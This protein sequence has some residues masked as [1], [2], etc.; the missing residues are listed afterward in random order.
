VT[1]DEVAPEIHRIE[2]DIGPRFVAQ[3]LLVGDE[4]SV[5]VDTGLAHTPDEALAPA[6]E[7][8]GVRPDL[9]LVSHADLDHCGGNRR[10][11]ERYP[12][13]LLACH[14]LDRRWI[15]SNQA[16]LVENYLWHEPYGLD[17]PDEEARRELL[18]GLGGDAPVDL[19]M[20]GGETIRLDPGRRVEVL[21]LPGHTAGHLGV[22]DPQERVAIIIDAALADGI[23][24][25][26]GNKLIPPRYYDAEAYRQTIR[27]IRAL[28]PGLLL[29][30]HYPPMAR[31]EARAFCDRSLGYV[32]EVERVV[33]EGRA[34][35]ETRLRQLT[36]RVDARVGPFPEFATEIA[37]GVRSHLAALA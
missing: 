18:A 28:E 12:G 7:G 20:R 19:G 32:D 9:I 10:M 30:A 23:Y 5:L 2:S 16:M 27:R 24:D 13:A 36:E 35:G 15:E 34:A 1:V 6:L 33:R 22:W 3:Y 4:R 14:E 11:R 31:A 26:M 25:R 17:Q 21:H 29:T 37:A 8:I